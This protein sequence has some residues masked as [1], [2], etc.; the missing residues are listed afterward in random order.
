MEGGLIVVSM[1]NLTDGGDGCHD[2]PTIWVYH[3]LLV[4]VPML[5][6][7]FF[8]DFS[9]PILVILVFS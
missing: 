3:Y 2:S 5:L 8:P 6:S 1:L 9:F 7:L 4:H